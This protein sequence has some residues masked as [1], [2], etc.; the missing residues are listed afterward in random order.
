M[1]I[2]IHITISL[3]F[4]GFFSCF[5]QLNVSPTNNASVLAQNIV[6]NNIQISNA[7]LNCA[8]SASG[9]F[10]SSSTNLGLP[11][12]ILLTTGSVYNA[13]GPNNDA[14]NLSGSACINPGASFSDPQISAIEPLAVYDGCVLQFDIVP[15]CNTLNIKYVFA[16]EEYPEYVNAG[17]NDAFGFF[18]SGP[19][20]GGGSYSNQ[21]I[22]LVPGSGNAVAIDNINGGFNAQYYVDNS[23]GGSIQYDGFTTPLIAAANVTPCATYHLK[24]AIADAGDCIYDSGVFLAFKGLTCPQT[25]IPSCTSATTPV[26]C[27]NDGTASVT[28]TNYTGT[29]T[30]QWSPVPGN[31]AS[32]SNLGPGTYTCVVGFSVPC[33][34]TQTITATVTGQNAIN[35][36]MNTTPST[37]NNPNG[38]ASVVASGPT[39]PYTYSWSTVPTQ[40]T[41]V[42]TGLVPGTYSVTIVD[43]NGCSVTNSIV[44]ANN[45]PVL[46]VVDSILNTT[47]GQPNGAIYIN[48]VSGGTQPYT[49]SWSSGQSTDDITG[50]TA[51]AYTLTVTD[52]LNCSWTFPY[53]VPDII[54]LPIDTSFTDERCEK[55]NGTATITVLNGVAP[56]NYVWSTTP[57]QTGPTAT[58]LSAG[59]Y[60]VTVTDAAGCTASSTYTILNINDVFNGGVY[61]SPPDPE[62]NIA[63]S[64][65]LLSPSIWML[66]QSN[67]PDGT[68]SNQP[69]DTMFFTDYG[70]YNGSFYVTS[71]NGCV[72]TVNYTVFVKDFM[73]LYVPNAFTPNRD[74]KNDMFC[75]YGTLIK[76]F[77]MEVFDRWG[78]LLF[79][80]DDL[81]TGWD[82]FYKGEKV[83]S[84]VYVWKVEA[85]DFFDIAHH[86]IGH[87]TVVR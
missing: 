31:T 11:A 14:G 77:K 51:I 55:A 86:L 82:G 61:Y 50:I 64:V 23:G 44:I 5:A 59:S 83:Q 76:S 25:Q 24:I 81:R 39:A 68:V 43:N 10:V 12:G 18:I 6:G 52:N 65:T 38:T 45:Q 30:Y 21:N 16:S 28:V 85:T 62:A 1:R 63:F 40:T 67:W 80:S 69:S 79:E 46:N 57:V 17:Y 47:C 60:T 8:G 37:C 56:F 49:Y 66:D 73:T 35:T 27:G 53:T 32:I 41:S 42:A 20:P 19:N 7:Q 9:T 84:D 3:F 72:D 36:V 34:Y 70:Y 26:L 33:P 87:V 2:K 74:N 22:A 4:A 48:S 58:G 75:A 78:I 29:P 15:I 54:N 13:I 71:V